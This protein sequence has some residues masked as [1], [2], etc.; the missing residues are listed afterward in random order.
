M[1]KTTRRK[2]IVR[3]LSVIGILGVTAWFGKRSILTWLVRRDNDQ[4]PEMSKAPEIDEEICILSSPVP[5]GP[6]YIK[7]PSRSDIRENKKGKTLNLKFQIVN[8]P[9]C[10]PIE[11]A[12]VEIWHCDAE[13]NYS[14]YPD[15][16]GHNV[17][18]FA[19]LTK[20][21]SKQRVEK[22]NEAQFLRGY[23]KS[24]SNGNV[25]FTTIVPGWYDPRV[26]HIHFKIIVENKEHFTSQLYFDQLFCDNLYTTIEPY[27]QYGKSPYTF[28][29]DKSMSRLDIAKGL[30]L[31][32]KNGLDDVSIATIKVGI[33]LT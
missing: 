27:K 14:G 21:G 16:I 26:P 10:E 25:G 30:I 9:N 24:D 32:P 5:E 28:K 7:S 29:N 18:E 17:W 1:R 8:Y 13:G 15:G 23:Q 12:V 6:Y 20:F 11:N 3:V 33:K 4:Y 2:F 19:K 31:N 22:S